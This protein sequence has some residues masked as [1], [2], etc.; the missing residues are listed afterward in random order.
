M[1][2]VLDAKI[3]TQHLFTARHVGKLKNIVSSWLERCS[4]M[5]NT[6]FRIR[7]RKFLVLP[8]PEQ[9]VR[10]KVGTPRCDATR[11]VVQSA[12]YHFA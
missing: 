9:L 11:A 3:C 8:D 6:V 1:N 2:Y 4:L 5:S 10:G 7:I 12:Q